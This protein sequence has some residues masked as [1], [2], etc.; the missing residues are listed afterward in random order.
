[1]P[2]SGLMQL[3]GERGV[4]SGAHDE[5]ASVLLALCRDVLGDLSADEE[6]DILR[7]RIPHID[8]TVDLF[9]AD[10]FIELLPKEDQKYAE[11][12]KKRKHVVENVKEVVRK[13]ARERKP[14][15]RKE[16]ASASSGAVPEMAKKRG[17]P[18]LKPKA[19][20]PA[21]AE[22]KKPR[23]YPP[24]FK[25][26]SKMTASDYM[27]Y[28]P[29]GCRMSTD[30]L[31]QNWRLSAWGRRYSRAW[32]LYGYEESATMLIKQAWQLALDLGYETECPYE[33]L[34]AK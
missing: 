30:K 11:E 26:S 4:A 6:L 34:E 16:S 17:R 5:F 32:R 12:Q 14:D 25:T 27:Q 22:T 33:H 19:A 29:S 1:M 8:E 21:I 31:D 23:R 10:E 15:V 7:C 2:R 9:H 20:A 18:P 3:V 24:E 28:L 13:I